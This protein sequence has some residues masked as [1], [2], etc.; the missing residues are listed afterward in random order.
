MMAVH[1]LFLSFY[2]CSSVTH[3]K[4]IGL[5]QSHYS[6]P[7][8]RQLELQISFLHHSSSPFF[9]YL[10]ILSSGNEQNYS[11]LKI[12]IGFFLVIIEL[13]CSL[14]SIKQRKYSNGLIRGG[15][16]FYREKR[17]EKDR[18]KRTEM[19]GSFW[20]HFSCK[21]V[22]GRQSYKNNIRLVQVTSWKD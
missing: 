14:F 16:K 21:A 9:A 12:P 17:A 8:S 7:V 15:S 2:L 3:T 20:S 19:G 11:Y 5:Y 1:L 4:A 10:F 6:M 22:T 18:N 13:D